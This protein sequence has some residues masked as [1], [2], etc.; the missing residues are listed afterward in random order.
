[1]QRDERAPVQWSPM[2]GFNPLLE[3]HGHRMVAKRWVRP[4]DVGRRG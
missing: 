1:M 4:A 2:A 3:R